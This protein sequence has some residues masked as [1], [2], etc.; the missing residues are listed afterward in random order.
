MPSPPIERIICQRNRSFRSARFYQP[1]A[2]LTTKQRVGV[3]VRLM[4]I[5]LSYERLARAGGFR[6]RFA[7]YASIT[8]RT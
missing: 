4:P 3:A 6:A 5:S 2:P 8:L 7:A 1:T